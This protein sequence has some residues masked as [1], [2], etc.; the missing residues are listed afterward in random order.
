MPALDQL[1]A[2]STPVAASES[3]T[4]VTHDC[5]TAP[6]CCKDCE[7]HAGCRCDGD[8]YGRRYA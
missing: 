6:E 5:Y 1:G 2:M 8:Y 7:T 3:D 4:P